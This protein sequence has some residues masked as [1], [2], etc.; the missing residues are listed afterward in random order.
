MTKKFINIDNDYLEL[1]EEY[2]KE[3]SDQLQKLE[4]IVLAGRTNVDY[5][6]IKRIA[7]NIKGS[8]GSYGIHIVSDLFQF[9]EE[10]IKKLET[11]NQ[12]KLSDDLIDYLLKYL[13]FSEIIFK[14]IE[15]KNYEITDII[16]KIES[17]NLLSDEI[18]DFSVEKKKEKDNEISAS[19]KEEAAKDIS[20]VKDANTAE[21]IKILLI[22]DSALVFKI[23]STALE[24]YKDS[25]IMSESIPKALLYMIKFKPD[26]IIVNYVDDYFSGTG[27]AAMLKLSFAFQNTKI[28]VITSKND[29]ALI[30]GAKYADYI[31]QKDAK[32]YEKILEI[33][34]HFKK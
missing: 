14:R 26:I 1:I 6:L 33:L 2:I 17:L 28:I 3:V 13:D 32:M 21:K 11:Q 4:D 25:L 30:K 20:N 31:I 18:P 27:L 7:H 19:K 12:Q 8:A 29:D 22:T 16:E 15:V 5:L 23:F 34:K 9:F 10:K 24:E